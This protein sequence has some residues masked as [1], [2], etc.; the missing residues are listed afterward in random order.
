MRFHKGKKGGAE[1]EREEGK[2]SCLLVCLDRSV[3]QLSFIS[4]SSSSSYH[5]VFIFLSGRSVGLSVRKNTLRIK[6]FLFF[7]FHSSLFL[8]GVSFF[9]FFFQVGG[10]RRNWRCFF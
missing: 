6:L 8:S 9:L 3:G 1:K 5:F 4:P 7:L 2:K 10:V